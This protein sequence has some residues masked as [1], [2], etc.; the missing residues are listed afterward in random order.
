MTEIDMSPQKV[1]QRLRRVA[2]MRRLC[3]KLRS[4]GRKLDLDSGVNGQIVEADKTKE[5]QGPWPQP[6]SKSIR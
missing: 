4:A 1:S 3:L 5:Q 2:Q 6:S